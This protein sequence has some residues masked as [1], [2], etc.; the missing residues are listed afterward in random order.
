MSD[1]LLPFE[2]LWPRVAKVVTTLATEE[3][4]TLLW[5]LRTDLGLT[6]TKYGCGIGACGSCTVVVDGTAVRSCQTTLMEVAGKEVTTIEGLGTPAA[7]HVLQEA[8]VA[9]QVAQCGYCQSGQIMQA[10]SLLASNPN[11]SAEEIVDA[12][13]GVICR[14]GTYQ[15]IER[16]ISSVAGGDS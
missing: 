7:M 5:V 1:R 4:R 16:A 14:C 6:G 3:D 10:A 11:P 13:N 9:H 2:E 15:R 12:M 8:W